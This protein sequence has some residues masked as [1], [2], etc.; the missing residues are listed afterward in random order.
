MNTFNETTK[1]EQANNYQLPPIELLNDYVPEDF[2]VTEEELIAKKDAIAEV[3]NDYQIAFN[4]ISATVGSTVTLFEVVPATG[5]RLSKVKCLGDD[6]VMSLATI[7]VRTIIPIPGR[8]T[9]GIEVPN[10]KPQIVPIRSVIASKQFQESNY[11]LP[12][13]IGKTC[14]NKMV[15]FDL[16]KAP[17]L[18]VAGAAGQGKT[19][20]I[21]TILTSLLYKKRPSELKLVL[22]DPKRVEL[23]LYKPLENHFLAKMPNVNDAIIADTQTIVSTLQSLCTEMDSR[24]DLMKNSGCRNIREYNSNFVNQKLNPDGGHRYLPYIVVIIDEYAD[25]VLNAGKDREVELPMARLA[26]LARAVGIHLIIAT[27][28]P[29]TNVITGLIKANFPARIAFRVMSQIDSRTILDAP[30]ANQLIGRGDM[31]IAMG[32]SEITRVQ[33]AIA[34]NNEIERVIDYI[35]NQ[36]GVEDADILPE[37]VPQQVPQ[38]DDYVVDLSRLDPLFEEAARVVV[39]CQ[40][41]STALIQR[42][43]SLGYNRAGRI[44]DQLEAAGIVGPFLGSRARSVLI[45]DELALERVLERLDKNK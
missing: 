28:R 24:Y 8:G 42:T 31:L 7:G 9:I 32:G 18:I 30:G 26:Q 23:S 37:V 36:P 3:L 29:T 15:A 39:L 43:F 21:N 25:L 11:E 1:A 19:V 5:V 16:T 44:M 40:Q 45:P 2:A 33:C 38:Q 41:G 10:N 27:Q 20:A 6:I 34:D 22:I 12:I 14:D 35:S 17:H 13:A 4:K